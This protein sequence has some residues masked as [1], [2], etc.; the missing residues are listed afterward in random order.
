MERGNNGNWVSF[1]QRNSDTSV[2]GRF[3]QN[4]K[5][6][7][8]SGMNRLPIVDI[9]TKFYHQEIDAA[10]YITRYEELEQ[11][12]LHGA[13]KFY[14]KMTSGAY[15]SADC[16]YA[17]NLCLTVGATGAIS[18]LF[19]YMHGTEKERSIMLLGYHYFLFAI[20][21]KRYNFRYTTLVN[22]S[23]TR[24]IPEI[25]QIESKFQMDK[26]KYVFLTMPSNPS[27]EIYTKKE[28]QE[29]LELTKKYNKI[30]VVDKCLWDDVV[31]QNQS[32]YYSLSKLILS[33][34]A[35]KNVVVIN[36]FSKIRGVPGIRFGYLMGSKDLIQFVKYYC[37]NLYCM[38]TT[39]YVMPIAIDLF[40]QT[41]LACKELDSNFLKKRFRQ[42]IMESMDQKITRQILLDFLRSYASE[43]KSYY[44]LLN[45][46]DKTMKE[47]ISNTKRIFSNNDLVEFTDIKT[48]F[49][50]CMVY[51]NPKQLSEK[52]LVSM[53]LEEIDSRMF[54]QANFCATH[55]RKSI[56]MRLSCAESSQVFLEKIYRLNKLLM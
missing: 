33:S 25:F 16:E 55:Y 40:F 3:P 20:M 8:S 24:N 7:I 54:T 48:G 43:L 36:S 27:G 37:N 9:Y 30:L 1:F 39:S 18:S 17:D 21:A 13:V 44:C 56:W 35:E 22:N 12:I 2:L 46:N 28:M 38:N 6:D 45:E 32:E 52:Q 34:N 47:V 19:E 4:V 49:N 31:F 29:V 5:N 15:L 26:G 10:S 51:K 11:P 14:E 41:V 23:E 42:V 53:I 50:F